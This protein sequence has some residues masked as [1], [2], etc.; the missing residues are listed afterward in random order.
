[1][2][3][4]LKKITDLTIND[5]LNKNI[6]LPYTYFDKYNNKDTY[7]LFKFKTKCCL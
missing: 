2:R 3:Q 4:Q 5:I 1:M 7:T 6:I